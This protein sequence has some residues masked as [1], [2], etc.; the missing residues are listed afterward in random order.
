M[1]F[2]CKVGITSSSIGRRF[3]GSIAMPYN[4]EVIKDLKLDPDLVYD[5]ENKIIRD[6]AGFR[7][8]PKISFGGE[9]ECFSE[10]EPILKLLD[11]LL[12]S[13]EGDYDQTN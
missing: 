1:R 12:K 13:I 10:L 2:F 7:Y 8:E 11:K 5:I 9:T 6:L 4:Y 3:A